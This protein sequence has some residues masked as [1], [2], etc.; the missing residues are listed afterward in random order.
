MKKIKGMLAFVM[1]LTIIGTVNVSANEKVIKDDINIVE[2]V[3][4][5]EEEVQQKADGIMAERL[6]SKTRTITRRAEKVGTSRTGFIGERAALGQPS[7]GYVFVDGGSI[8]WQDSTQIVGNVNVSL[9]FGGKNFTASVGI[10]P[11]KASQSVVGVGVK[12]PSSLYNKHVK[13]FVSRQY[14]VTQ[15]KIYEYDTYAGPVSEK[16]IGYQYVSIPVSYRFQIK[17]V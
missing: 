12:V 13:L 16:F 6:N 14:D 2:K 4:Y 7:A 11:G 9:S 15:Y 8:Y 17:G 10:S 1:M 5:T 3:L